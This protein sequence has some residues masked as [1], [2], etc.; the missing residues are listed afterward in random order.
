[1]QLPALSELSF[2]RLRNVAS[3]TSLR[4]KQAFLGKTQL[5]SLRE[6]QAFIETML[7]WEQCMGTVHAAL[8]GTMMVSGADQPDM[9]I[10]GFEVFHRLCLNLRDKLNIRSKDDLEALRQ[11]FH[12]NFSF[13]P[14]QTSLLQGLKAFETNLG[15]AGQVVG[16]CNVASALFAMLP[17]STGVLTG[18]AHSPSFYHSYAYFRELAYTFDVQDAGLQFLKRHVDGPANV[19][20][21]LFSFTATFIVSQIALLKEQCAGNFP[22]KEIDNFLA[23]LELAEAINPFHSGLYR[24]RATLYECRGR[25]EEAE[26]IRQ[27]AEIVKKA[28][29]PIMIL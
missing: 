12:S 23:L 20:S 9:I 28:T 10:E 27:F 19:V 16:N 24:L 26:G 1:M 7:R 11:V 13:R 25:M 5:P 2:I 15:G 29:V 3:P 17:A 22:E 6:P 14:L 8:A 18:E 4:A 21:N